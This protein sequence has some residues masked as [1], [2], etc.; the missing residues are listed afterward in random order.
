MIIHL[1]DGTYELFRHYYG[2][3]RLPSKGLPFGAVRALSALSRRAEHF[4]ESLL[5][6]RHL[7]ESDA[8][9]I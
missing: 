3:Q 9:V 7:P 6:I 8:Q 5:E 4:V 1:I 2:L